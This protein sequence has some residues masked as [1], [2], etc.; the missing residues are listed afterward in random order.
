MQSEHERIVN[1]YK[2]N[3]KS[4]EKSQTKPL[5]LLVLI[6]AIVVCMKAVQTTASLTLNS[7][8]TSLVLILL[9]IHF[10]DFYPRRALYAESTNIILRGL[11]LEMASSFSDLSFFKKHLKDF[12]ALGQLIKMA[13]FDLMLIYFFS[14]S[15]TQLL[16]GIDPE[17]MVKLRPITP[18]STTIIDLFLG[19]AYYQ[20]IKPLAHVR[21][22]ME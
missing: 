20:V 22:E 10:W 16:K 15:Y 11:D 2:N 18:I 9:C 3:E 8:A 4:I 14:V 7:I 1:Q 5:I 21:R 17:F 6:I 13:L 12:N 19:I